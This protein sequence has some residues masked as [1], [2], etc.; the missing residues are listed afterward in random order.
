MN[1]PWQDEPGI[2][3]KDTHKTRKVESGVKIYKYFSDWAKPPRDLI[4]LRGYRMQDG[5]MAQSFHGK[6]PY[7]IS[8]EMY[9]VTEVIEA[10][11]AVAGGAKTIEERR[12][13]AKEKEM[14]QWMR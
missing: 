2:L 5:K 1:T 7:F 12:G 14:R 9:Q 3:I 4:G 6:K 8:F 11:R 13:E 10:L